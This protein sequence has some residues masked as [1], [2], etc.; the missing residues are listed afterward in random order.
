MKN[1]PKTKWRFAI[2]T[3][4][5]VPTAPRL[6]YLIADVDGPYINATLA[7]FAWLGVKN[8]TLQRTRHGWHVYT[9]TRMPW[10]KLTATLSRTPGVDQAWL[11]I[12][13]TRGYLFLADK[14]AVPLNWS[15]KRMVLTLAKKK[16]QNA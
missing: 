16:T 12:G 2:G 1:Q 8:F 11:R 9:K 13:L 10:R 14:H 4:S 3:T 6:H 15:V 7:H 5:L